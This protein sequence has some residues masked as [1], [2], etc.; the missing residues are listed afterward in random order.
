MWHANEVMVVRW[1]VRTD[2]NGEMLFARRADIQVPVV[3]PAAAE[4]PSA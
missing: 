3:A 1:N 4:R 2:A